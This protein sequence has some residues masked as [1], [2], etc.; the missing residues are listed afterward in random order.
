M[1]CWCLLIQMCPLDLFRWADYKDCFV[2]SNFLLCVYLCTCV[3]VCVCHSVLM[4]TEDNCLELVLF[5]CVRWGD[6]TEVLNLGNKYLYPLSQLTESHHAWL[7]IIVCM[8]VSV[9]VNMTWHMSGDQ[10]TTVR[11]LSF[12][13]SVGSVDWTWVLRL[14]WQVGFTCWAI[15]TTPLFYDFIWDLACL[16]FVFHLSQ[17]AKCWHYRQ[18]PPC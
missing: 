18:V 2:L 11:S 17:T 15:L 3:C 10:R 13:S 8:C 16:E 14:V 7:L 1:Q 4:E 5:Y 6:W 9:G 12:L